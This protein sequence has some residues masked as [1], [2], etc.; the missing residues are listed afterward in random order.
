M[1][2]VV[3]TGA[4]TARRC[5]E[6]DRPMAHARQGSQGWAIGYY[7]MRNV[8]GDLGIQP[9]S[10]SA[11]VLDGQCAGAQSPD[12]SVVCPTSIR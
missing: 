7:D 6:D 1:I 5:G 9:D 3:M 11:Y 10:F 2:A 8:A 4:S 12:V